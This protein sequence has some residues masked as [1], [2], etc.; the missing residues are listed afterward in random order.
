MLRKGNAER[1]GF[2]PSW[3]V[4]PPTAFPVRRPRPTRRSLLADCIRDP[5]AAQPAPL[6]VLPEARPGYLP[7]DPY[8][9]S[10]ENLRHVC[11][12][13]IPPVHGPA[14][15]VGL[16]A[17]RPVVDRLHLPDLLA[18]RAGL[19]TTRR[20]LVLLVTGTPQLG[21]PIGRTEAAPLYSTLPE[22]CPSG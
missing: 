13:R 8:F 20:T 10:G 21:S 22:R 11:P 5:R 19:P 18:D 9:A 1:E 4:T 2:E 12:L 16:R 3:R 17:P 14:F 15:R 6:M 7:S